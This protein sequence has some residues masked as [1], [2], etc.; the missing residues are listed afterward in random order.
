MSKGK[1]RSQEKN[2]MIDVLVL[3]MIVRW[4]NNPLTKAPGGTLARTYTSLDQRWTSGCLIIGLLEP[5]EITEFVL[6]IN[7]AVR[8]RIGILLQSC[9]SLTW[10]RFLFS[11]LGGY[12]QM[13]ILKSILVLAR[14]VSELR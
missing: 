10:N 7:S 5:Q 2:A 3:A 6:L 4:L 9:P 12:F 13:K 1:G 11:K 14:R 8:E